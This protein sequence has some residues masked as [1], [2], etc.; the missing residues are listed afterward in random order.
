MSNKKISLS[1]P[2][3]DKDV[4]FLMDAIRF[5][6]KQNPDGTF[7]VQVE[8]DGPE[9]TVEE[10]KQWIKDNFPTIKGVPVEI[11]VFER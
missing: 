1:G 5:C 9:K 7:L 6:E 10:T 11:E 4:A 8:D 3:T 2:F